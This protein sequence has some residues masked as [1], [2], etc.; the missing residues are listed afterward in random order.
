MLTQ[1]D[2][3]VLLLHTLTK[4]VHIPH[5]SAESPG[6]IVFGFP[7]GCAG[8]ITTPEDWNTRET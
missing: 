7:R 2:Q 6:G 4:Y 5:S 1:R 8:H 3:R